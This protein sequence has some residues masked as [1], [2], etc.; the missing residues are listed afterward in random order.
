MWEEGKK[1]DLVRLYKRCSKEHTE[2]LQPSI[3]LDQPQASASGDVHDELGMQLQRVSSSG[4]AGESGKGARAGVGTER[5]RRR[6]KRG[7]GIMEVQLIVLPILSTLE[8]Q[9]AFTSSTAFSLPLNKRSKRV[10]M[11][12]KVVLPTM[13]AKWPDSRTTPAANAQQQNNASIIHAHP[14]NHIRSSIITSPLPPHLN[15]VVVIANAYGT[16][17]PRNPAAASPPARA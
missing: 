12:Q 1:A 6:M 5:L 10:P 17:P 9:A 3:S 16:A 11:P 15:V 14:S 13:M 8:Q 7:L 4:I 2:T